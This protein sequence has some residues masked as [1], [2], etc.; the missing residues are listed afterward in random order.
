MPRYHELRELAPRDVVT[1]SIV[2]EMEPDRDVHRLSRHDR[3][4]DAAIVRRRFPKIYRDV[5]A[6][7]DSISRASPCPSAPP[8]TT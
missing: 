4:L 2:A 8:R 6:A 7:T 5:L 1:R 3:H